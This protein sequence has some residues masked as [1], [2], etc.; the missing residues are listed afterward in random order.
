[1]IIFLFLKVLGIKSKAGLKILIFLPQ[2]SKNR[3]H[4][5]VTLGHLMLF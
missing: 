2:T 5:L 1:M 4:R 3:D